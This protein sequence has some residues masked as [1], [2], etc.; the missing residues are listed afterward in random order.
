MGAGLLSS[1]LSLSQRRRR[2]LPNEKPASMLASAVPKG[3]SLGEAQS[4]GWAGECLVWTGRTS[5]WNLQPRYHSLH[6]VLPAPICPSAPE[7]GCLSADGQQLLQY[8]WWDRTPGQKSSSSSTQRAWSLMTLWALARLSF[9]LFP[10]E[11]RSWEDGGTAWIPKW[12]CW[13]PLS[14][15][16]RTWLCP[17]LHVPVNPKK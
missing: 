3:M 6:P 1:H 12:S 10:P 7:P 2:Q 9:L 5:C 14:T 17:H 8:L 16:A 11:V 13:H 4:Q 15:D